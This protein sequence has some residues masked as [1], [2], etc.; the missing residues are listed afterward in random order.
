LA[1][2]LGQARHL[3]VW[4]VRKAVFQGHEPNIDHFTNILE[5]FIVTERRSARKAVI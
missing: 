4:N 2:K 3:E 1:V 5:L